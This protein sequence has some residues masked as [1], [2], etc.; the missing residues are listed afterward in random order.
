M[1]NKKSLYDITC[2]SMKCQ[3]VQRFSIIQYPPIVWLKVDYVDMR[4]ILFTYSVFYIYILP[5]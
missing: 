3:S 2:N 4:N 1:V 5:I